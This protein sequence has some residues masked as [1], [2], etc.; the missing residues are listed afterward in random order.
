MMPLNDTNE[1]PETALTENGAIATLL[2]SVPPTIATLSCSIPSLAAP[3]VEEFIGPGESEFASRNQIDPFF[4]SLNSVEPSS[5][6]ASVVFIF[7]GI[8]GPV[9][10]R[11][12]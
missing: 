12:A 7:C 4:G 11:F 3:E 1:T 9:R 6:D 10:V 8:G 2:L 5:G